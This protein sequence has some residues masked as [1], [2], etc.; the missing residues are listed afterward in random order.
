M[1]TIQLKFEPAN[2]KQFDFMWSTKKYLMLS[3]AV[4]AGKS[5]CGCWKGY[6][7]NLLYPGNRGLI[8][9][10][11]AK[12]L[13]GST[14][15][16][17]FEQVIPSSQIIAH[18][19][20]KGEIVHKTPV[21]GVNSTI[22]YGGLDKRA[23]QSYPTKIGSTEYGWIF[24]DEGTELIEGDWNMLSTRLRYRPLMLPKH[25]T[26]IMPRQLFTATNP[27]G[28]NHWL[29]KFFF[30]NS[31][32]DRQVIL[33]TPYDNPY[34][35]KDYMSM[36]ENNL[37]GIT[38]ER[39]LLGKW[40]QAEGIIYKNFNPRIHV[41]TEGFLPW[42]DYKDLVIGADS[43]Y[44]L[45]RAAVLCGFKGEDTV[46]VL[47]EFYKENTHVEDLM[48]W[49][50]EIRAK[51]QKTIYIYHD[52]SDPAAIEKISQVNGIVSEKADNKVSGEIGGISEVGKYFDSNKILIHSSCTN[53]VKE[54]L[55]Y[56]WKPEREG[57]MPLKEMDHLCDAIRYALY[58][59]RI[60]SGKI[61]MLDPGKYF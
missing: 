53:L 20:Q 34:L 36:L 13:S 18:N 33:T 19:Q 54:L 60:N 44:P 47:A 15:K 32:P 52:P 6:T 4:A 41:T 24:V 37:T 17:L 57:E 5:L 3:G 35:P 50:E 42:H 9:R 22:I 58:T 11:E 55:N 49:I 48:K 1:E 45:P 31:H 14:L 38:R 28:P 25:I 29:H 21:P 51:A 8:C 46:H 7:L 30:E 61:I 43:N 40:V 16:T 56:R 2:K 12:S 10:K 26:D 27:D 39:L 23:D 59:H